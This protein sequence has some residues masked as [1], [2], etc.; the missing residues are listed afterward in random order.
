MRIRPVS[1]LNDE[2]QETYQVPNSAA[3]TTP[4]RR[5]ASRLRSVLA[6]AAT[7][8]LVLTGIATGAGAATA[9]TG[10]AS[11]PGRT[12]AAAA[13]P[14]TLTTGA[15]RVNGLENPLGIAGGAPTFSWKSTSDARGVTQSAYEVRVAT[16]VDALGSADVWSSGKV[17][18][19][20]Q[21][22]V[23]Y[24]GPA[25][26]SQTP[27]VWQVRTWSNLGAE[28][29]WS[30][31]GTFETAILNP[32]EWQADWIGGPDPAVELD[33]WQNY[34]T[35]IDFTMDSL[36]LGVYLRASDLSNAYMW[37]LSVSDGTPRFRPHVKVNGGYSLL[38]SKDISS[39][40]TKE[41]LATGTH[42]FTVT[43]DGST[44]TTF[45]DGVQIDRRTNTQHS[46]GYVGFRQSVATEGPEE[47]TIHSIK[48][49][50]PESGVLLD[51]DFSDGTNPFG[52]GTITPTGLKLGAPTETIVRTQ[53][54]E[55]ILRKDFDVAAQ[56]TVTSARVYASARGVYE[57]SLNGQK[58]GDQELAPGWTNYS[59]RIAYQT[60]DVTDLVTGGAN[61]FGA[62]LGDGW[63]AG[64][65]A[66]FGTGL[67]GTTT[68]VIAQL[69]IDYSD[70]TSDVVATD[71]SWK[72]S[73]GPLV[74]S[75]IIM[76]ERYDARRAQS[77]WQSP[78]YDA[79]TWSPVAVQDAADSAATRLLEPATDQPVRVTEKRTP[80]SVRES[81]PGTWIYDLG[82]NMVGVAELTLAGAAGQTAT[83]RYGEMLNPDGTLYTANLRSAKV[84]DYYTFAGNTADPG[85]VVSETYTPTFTFHGFRYLEIT[86]VGT[87]PTA[88]EVT[89]LVWGSDL[90]T[91][92]SL[93]TSS[94]MLNQLQSNITW[95]Q[96][97][98]F[99]S[100]PT[101]TPARDERLGWTGDINVFAP[102]ASFNQD[103]LAF[104]G[105]WLVDLT[106]SQGSN[107]DLPGVAPM[108]AGGCCGGGTGWSD[109][110]ITV[111][112]T[113]W[114]SYGD[115]GV[116]RDNYAM[117]STF[118]DY[119]ES[120]TGASLIRSSG[121]YGD[122]LHLDD[123]TDASLLGTAYY[124]FITDQM[125]QMAA[126]IGETDDAAHYAD[127]SSR[128][129]DA[130]AARFIATDG[131]VQGNSQTGYAIA[132]GMGLVPEGQ[133][134]AV[135]EKFVA[136]IAS[137]DFHLS[138]G[139]LGTPWLLPALTKTGHQ[140]VA[141]R[142]LNNDTYPSWGYEVASGATTMWERWDSL[143]PDGSFGDVT[144]NSFNHYAYGAVGDWMYQNIGGIQ[145]TDA[146][147]KTF[148]VAP[149]IGGGLTH[150]K[151]TFES[152]YGTISSDWTVDGSTTSLAVSVPVNTTATVTIP[153]ANQWAVT[154]GGVPLGQVPG[155]TIVAAPAGQVVVQLGSGDY[156][157]DSDPANTGLTVTLDAP[158]PSALPGASVAGAL[159]VTNTGAAAVTGFRAGL[160]VSGGLT[161]TPATV[162]VDSLAAGESTTLPF[163]VQVP[164]TT[165]PGAVTV[166][167][168]I[169]AT[170]GSE[171]RR[172]TVT[173]TL[174]TLEPAVTFTST[175][176]TPSS[177]DSPET[178]AVNATVSNAAATA[179]TGRLVVDTPAGWPAPLASAPVTVPA[180]G[181]ADA[182]V[183]ASVPLTV[184]A[185]PTALTAR[186]VA[187]GPEGQPG[188]SLASTPVSFDVVLTTPPAGATDHVDLGDGP[189]EAAHAVTSSNNGGTSNE[190]GLSRR[191]SG[192]TT[193]GSWFQFDLAVTP[194]EP[195]LIRGIETFDLTQTKSY[196]IIVNG[197]TVN[198]RI[199][200]H[201]EN[202][203]GLA[204]YQV[205]VPDDGTLTSTGKVTIRMR[206][207]GKGTHDPSLAD[208]WTL[209]VPAD[210]VAPSTVLSVSHAGSAG[211]YLGGAQA[212]IQADDARSGVAS[213]EYRLG[214]GEWTTYDSAIDLPEGA[215]VLSYRATDAAGNVSAERSETLKVDATAP[216][217]WGWL[218]TGNDVVAFGQ[219]GGSGVASIEY[220]LD[221][222]VWTPGL[223][224]L[225][226]VDAEPAAL[227]L[228]TVDVA[229]NRGATLAL[230]PQ[231]TPELLE[232][233]PGQSAIVEASGFTPGTTVRVELHSDPV[234]LGEAVADSLGAISLTTTVPADLPAGAHSLVLVPLADP[235]DPGTDPGTPGTG[236]SDP[237][238]TGP[239]TV[240]IPASI[241]ASTGQTP[242]P[243]IAAGAALLLLGAAVL[244]L[245][246]RRR[247]TATGEP[248][249]S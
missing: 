179:V 12:A 56:K 204:T 96:R 75:D 97:G 41:A 46:E 4:D 144:M 220:S 166:Q 82:Q 44:I 59:K 128:V 143:K 202:A 92:G 49:V 211:W 239:G 71:D 122:W 8:A 69:R 57:L 168:D 68:S 157:F 105:K 193:I 31:P 213:I 18:S 77:G 137:R 217:T 227:S 84:T 235:V 2:T 52:A 81:A 38:E 221:G 194:N 93:E 154:E 245:V 74:E 189:S 10:V 133:L 162:S 160:A 32:D 124:S 5:F 48:V 118:M 79:A 195:F 50:S 164:V 64:H 238:G 86:G 116:I 218:T 228:R 35:T 207:N 111:P 15:L 201:V 53:P 9:S 169:D 67:W 115:T 13:D 148:A 119:V 26:E 216:T 21:L 206:F 233:A 150:G 90:A 25:L 229:G 114:K 247:R 58:V 182:T 200:H 159:T 240:T 89:G 243:Y 236:G 45:L 43:L 117:M 14:G 104:L 34:T 20:E 181:T 149:S 127:L 184:D 219:D 19:A 199:Y 27:Y 132:I 78:G 95:G 102:T 3:S 37:Q 120:S 51:T 151:G 246:R 98:N 142:L 40:I 237:A 186:F 161:A 134:Q 234:V 177:A 60:Y 146:G 39:F 83:I 62:M 163:T 136:K 226:A 173:G 192:V 176:A 103:T 28:S 108:T 85:A 80:I 6:L 135:G 129:K 23:E 47:S 7:G 106:D 1:S 54:A 131:T 141:Y 72:A 94:A 208:V 147:Y 88:D 155:V 109:A 121:G 66:S 113:L 112:Y 158:T 156:A 30:E 61:T 16:S 183:V 196:D 125:S 188:A 42:E 223:S 191:Y 185:G 225:L 242:L 187:D 198:E 205:L 231:G 140:D 73:F 244:Y 110:G 180:G 29:A 215:T 70:G 100:I 99:L 249:A 101:D 107:G 170:V 55:P 65:V 224:A 197:T 36:V 175:R 17:D 165:P 203:P 214:S 174:V 153:A 33:R 145:A 241:L 138:T 212:T 232:I 230:T 171:P 248:T 91:T 76:G 222:A 210:S 22:N 167:A 152:V 87:A 123:G 63:Y 11:S 209:P 172:F 126:A 24:A 130:F 178:V 190:A 139:F